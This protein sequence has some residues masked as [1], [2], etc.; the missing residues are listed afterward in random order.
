MMSDF[1][2]P[3]NIGSEEMVTINKLIDIIA[4]ISGKSVEKRYILNA[5]TGVR[6]RNSSNNL[7]RA[8]LGWDYNMTLAKGLKITYDWIDSQLNSKIVS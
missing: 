3:I 5:P 8:V 1:S 4:E 6:G 2:D 7:I